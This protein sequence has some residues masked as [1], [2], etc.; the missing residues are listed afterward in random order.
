VCHSQALRRRSFLISMCDCLDVHFRPDVNVAPLL[1]SGDGADSLYRMKMLVLIA[2]G[3]VVLFTIVAGFREWPRKQNVR[4]AVTVRTPEGPR[5]GESIIELRYKKFVIPASSGA[6]SKTS[7]LGEAA[8]VELP[9]KP[10]LFMLV[11]DPGDGSSLITMLQ[12]TLF[13]GT[14]INLL[15]SAQLLRFRDPKDVTSMELL[16][17]RDVPAAYGEGYA[18]I[19]VTAEPTSRP[20]SES[21]DRYLPSFARLGSWFRTLPPGDPRRRITRDRFISRY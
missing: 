14:S 21:I 15:H 6:T 5:T 17:V 2:V 1:Q 10:A 20:L 12:P 4:L 18:V 8:V 11:G 16:E 19:S 13:R 3:I 7:L 9:S